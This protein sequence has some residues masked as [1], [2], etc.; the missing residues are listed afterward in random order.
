MIK[1]LQTD[2]NTLFAAEFIVTQ[3]TFQ[4]KYIIAG[5]FFSEL[6]Q[7]A[8]AHYTIEEIEKMIGKAVL[9]AME[10]SKD[11]IQF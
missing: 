10:E 8:I 4:P 7:D 5:E 6:M 2:F 3:K 11:R 1:P 9:H